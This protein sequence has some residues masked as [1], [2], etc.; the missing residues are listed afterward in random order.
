MKILKTLNAEV[1]PVLPPGLHPFTLV[2][3][4]N[5]GMDKSFAFAT[6]S[7][8]FTVI[9]MLQQ[10]VFEKGIAMWLD[11]RMFCLCVVQNR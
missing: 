6:K 8:H 3:W 10:G 2:V 9:V 7:G 11:S 5:G 4:G 1:L